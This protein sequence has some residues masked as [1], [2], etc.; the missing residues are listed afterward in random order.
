MKSLLVEHDEKTA[1]RS[2]AAHCF[3]QEKTSGAGMGEAAN[4]RLIL[5][6]IIYVKSLLFSMDSRE[7]KTIAKLAVEEDGKRSENADWAAILVTTG[8]QRCPARMRFAVV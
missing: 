1:G 7:K 4:R 5:A 2:S 6:Q 8:I 3:A